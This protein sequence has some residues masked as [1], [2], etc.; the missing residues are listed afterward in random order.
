MS[1]QAHVY[2]KPIQARACGEAV[3]ANVTA[4]NKSQLIAVIKAI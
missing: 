4:A 1:A 2:C 3:T